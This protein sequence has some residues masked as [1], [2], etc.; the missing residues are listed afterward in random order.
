ME[1]VRNVL[2]S[3]MGTVLFTVYSNLLSE[4]CSEKM[5]AILGANHVDSLNL[6]SYLR[7]F[8]VFKE[9]TSA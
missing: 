1:D 3:R 4:I 5:S 2:V 7:I 6:E 8:T 9:N